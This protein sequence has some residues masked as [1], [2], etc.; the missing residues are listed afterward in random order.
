MTIHPATRLF[1]LLIVGIGLLAL[2]QYRSA[3]TLLQDW[4]RANHLRILRKR[5]GIPPLSMWFT[6][7]RNQYLYRVEVLDETTRRIRKGWI[8][9]G[10]FWW[11]TMS[12]DAVEAT[13]DEE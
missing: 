6:T 4:A 3:Q 5:R 8:K 1:P 7:S 2:R 11:G 9:L 12:P 13:W 10:T